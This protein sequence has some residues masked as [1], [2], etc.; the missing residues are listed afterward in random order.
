MEHNVLLF[1]GFALFAVEDDLSRLFHP[2]AA[3]PFVGQLER[4]VRILDLLTQIERDPNMSILQK[5]EQLLLNRAEIMRIA[6]RIHL[7]EPLPH[8][9]DHLERLPPILN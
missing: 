1:Y 7:L 4:S 8:P 3:L 9:L 5:L 2:R 6:S